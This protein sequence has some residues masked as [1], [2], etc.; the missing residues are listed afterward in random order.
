M[1]QEPD[2]SSYF[3]KDRVDMNGAI[4]RLFEKINF[5]SEPETIAFQNIVRTE[6]AFREF[7]AEMNWTLASVSFN[8]LMDEKSGDYAQRDD[9]KTPS[10]Y[11]EFSE[12]MIF[13][14]LIKSDKIKPET[15]GSDAAEI[16]V[17]GILRHDSWED[18]GKS[19]G[20]VYAELERDLYDSIE[21]MGPQEETEYITRR[22]AAAVS[23]IVDRMTRK[24]P[25]K[26]QEYIERYG[27]EPEHGIDSEDFVLKETGKRMKIDRFTNKKPVSADLYFQMHGREPEHGI[28]DHGY[29]LG[30]GGKRITV[31][32]SD[33]NS[34]HASQMTNP[35]S[36][37][38]KMIDSIC[39]VDSRIMPDYLDRKDNPKK[40][41]ST[42]DNMK[43]ARERR[44][45]Y[46][47]YPY[48]KEAIKHHPRFKDA[49][50][51]LDAIL[52]IGV[53]TLETV[54]HYYDQNSGDNPYKARPIDID[55][56]VDPAKEVL[57]VLP[58]GWRP[59]TLMLERLERVEEQELLR[60]SGTES[61]AGAILNHAL[62]P[63]FAPLIGEDRRSED[64]LEYER[65]M[66]PEN[67]DLAHGQEP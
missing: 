41:F 6:D 55:D 13:L 22:R 15:M 52:G 65:T 31:E 44:A 59:D 20:A 51:A 48:A 2:L 60:S 30:K 3:H 14:A 40:K 17:S 25:I 64:V 63:A 67:D 50:Q 24:T 9:G 32:K 62:Y 10:W 47:S 58:K 66:H 11:H 38:G 12:I 21:V 57:E 18:H 7:L 8:E 53:R 35:F 36:A 43:Y 39:G 34:Y 37:M 5:E 42:E 27:E 26:I 33:L 16:M 19:P 46:S 56:W 29:A 23:D 28:D 54:N 1:T 61:T 49:F 45:H 4:D